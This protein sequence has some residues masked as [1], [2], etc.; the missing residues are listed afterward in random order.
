[1]RIASSPEALE[2]LPNGSVIIDGGHVAMK[3]RGAWR[4]EPDG[5]FREPQKLPVQII[6]DDEYET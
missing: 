4:Y 3:V 2:A 6:R 5:K 1:M